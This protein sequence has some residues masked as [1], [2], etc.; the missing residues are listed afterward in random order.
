[1]TEFSEGRATPINSN[2]LRFLGTYSRESSDTYILPD[3]AEP[4]LE[5]GKFRRRTPE[6]MEQLRKEA[7]RKQAERCR[8]IYEKLNLKV[9]AYPDGDLEISW[10]GG[11]RK[12]LDTSR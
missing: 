2:W 4:T 7:E 9:V 8:R 6:E 1:M 10:T 11:V 5:P 12:L 3:E